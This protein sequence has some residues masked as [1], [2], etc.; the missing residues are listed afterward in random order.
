LTTAISHIVWHEGLKTTNFFTKP[1]EQAF[2]KLPDEL[3]EAYA[4]EVED[5]L[6]FST[7]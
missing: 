3:I 6:K 7:K 5:L 2:K 1:F 4:L